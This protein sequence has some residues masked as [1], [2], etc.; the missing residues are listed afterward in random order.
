MTFKPSTQQTKFFDW[1]TNGRGHAILEAVAGAGK[2]TTLVKAIELMPGDIAV[3]VFNKKLAEEISSKLTSEDDPFGSSSNAHASTFHSA[4]FSALR[5][6]GRPRVDGDKCKGIAR[7]LIETREGVDQL[8]NPRLRA[9]SPVALWL[10]SLAKNRL[11][12]MTSD[13]EEWHDILNHHNTQLPGGVTPDLVVE[14]A[15]DILDESMQQTG[16]VD[17]DDMIYL[18]VVQNLRVRQFDWVL[19]DEAQDT[20]PARRVLAG[21]MLK[22]GGRLVAVGDPQQAIY[23]FTGADNDALD[24]IRREYDAIT[25]P[26][27]VTF[28]CPRAVVHH[29]RSFGAQIEAAPDASTGHVIHTNEKHMIETIERMD[30][31]GRSNT[32]ILCRVTKCLVRLCYQF[33]RNGIPARIEGRAIGEGLIK[34]ATKWSVHELSDLDD[35]LEA[36][37]EREVRRAIEKEDESWAERVTDQ[38]D[39]LQLLIELTNSRGNHTVPDLV[40][41]IKELF[42]D[43]VSSRDMLTLATVHRAKGLE[44]ETVYLLGRKELMPSPWAEQKWMQEQEWNLVYVAITRALDTLV[45]VTLESK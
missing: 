8:Q 10:V 12:T 11:L 34:L 1:I 18:P 21:R 17:F 43:D 2:T 33:I 24:Q 42:E 29:A 22:P 26:L 35:R 16:R 7:M 5:R 36:Y 38:V 9:A 3:L 45:E 27:S 20:N 14:F 15:R 41:V 40:W 32:A 19:I 30:A 39:T 23:G 4:G 44:W 31:E 13:V 37:R 28:R 25:L 6:T